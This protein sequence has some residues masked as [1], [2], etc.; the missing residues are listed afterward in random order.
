MHKMRKELL[1]VRDLNKQ[2][3]ARVLELKDGQINQRATPARVQSAYPP[4]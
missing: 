2:L 4:G 1:E 3:N